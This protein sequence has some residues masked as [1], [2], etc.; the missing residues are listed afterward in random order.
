VPPNAATATTAARHGVPM[1][2]GSTQAFSLDTPC[3]GCGVFIDVTQAELVDGQLRC[4]SCSRGQPARRWQPL[5][6]IG[7]VVAT[8]V[9]VVALLAAA[10]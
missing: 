8:V 7:L 10:A 2:L 1:E 5:Y 9:V 3:D 6:V 4:P